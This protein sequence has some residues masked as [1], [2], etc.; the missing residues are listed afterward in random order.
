MLN[1]AELILA[2]DTRR[3]GLFFQRHGI[4]PQGRLCSFFEHNEQERI[5]AVLRALE[6]GSNVALI[7]DAGTPVIGDPGY[8]LV[9]TCREAGFPVSPIP[10][11]CAPVAALCASGLP[12]CPFSF[13]GFLPRQAGEKK[14]LF[15]TWTGIPTTL[16]FFERNSRLASTLAIA[17]ETLGPRELCLARELT[18]KHEQL[19]VDK[20]ENH[21]DLVWDPRGEMTVI[22]GPP[23][24][25][26][27]T[28][29][30]SVEQ[31]LL[32]ECQ[33]GLPREIA[34]RAAARVSGWSSKELYA[35]IVASPDRFSPGK[36]I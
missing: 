31:I 10:G 22:I 20:L 15:S 21:A 6:T 30:E 13:F 11:P 25:E 23:E 24:H 35:R 32:E 26:P 14:R 2:E 19:L 34:V 16:V 4:H 8:R 18:K 33:A 17:S 1:Q 9:R 29:E 5:P 3:A 28:P 12:P 7:S 36:R 27:K